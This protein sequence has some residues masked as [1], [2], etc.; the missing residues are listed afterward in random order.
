[1]TLALL[2]FL[3]SFARLSI[4]G[5]W[6]RTG[7]S[8]GTIISIAADRQNPAIWYAINGNNA[9]YGR[10]YRSTDNGESWRPTKIDK[11]TSVVVSPQS[12]EVFVLS[13][14]KDGSTRQLWVSK[15]Q[16]D[17][18]A[19]QSS[20]APLRLFLSPN[21]S[22]ILFGVPTT[23]PWNLVASF[24]GGR[25]WEEVTTLPFK[26]GLKY[27]VSPDCTFGY[28]EFKDVLISP[29]DGKTVYA[30]GEIHFQ[31]GSHN[32]DVFPVTVR[33]KNLGRSWSVS[34]FE[35]YNFSYDP[36][37]PKRAFSSNTASTSG[38]RILTE[39]GWRTL[40]RRTA[41][42]VISVPAQPEVLYAYN[43]D[44]F[45]G[46]PEY[47]VSRDF[48]RTWRKIKLGPGNGVRI[49][50]ARQTPPGSLLGGTLGGG[51]Y[52]LDE[53]GRWKAQQ[54]GFREATLVD[55]AGGPPSSI[56]YVIA[57]ESACCGSDSYLFRSTNN[58]KTWQNITDNFPAQNGAA[59]GLW[60][61]ITNP[62]N[63][64]HVIV[65]SGRVVII[66]FD[67]G[68][69]WKTLQKGSILNTYFHPVTN[70]VYFTSFRHLYRSRDGGL[71][72]EELPLKLPNSHIAFTDVEFDR[73]TNDIYLGSEQGM[74]VSDDGG[75]SMRPI[76]PEP[77]RNCFDCWVSSIVQL[78]GQG[79]FLIAATSGIYKTTDRGATWQRLSATPD[80]YPNLYPTDPDGNHVFAIHDI[81]NESND[82]GVTWK[83]I[84]RQVDPGLTGNSLTVSAMTNP[85]VLPWFISTRLGLYYKD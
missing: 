49:L 9:I 4:A 65:Q 59:H 85:F 50:V 72:I 28:Y 18:F 77:H 25:V 26:P 29:L 23:Y 22:S 24:N 12:S 44:I 67:A 38:I 41:I 32:E 27:D 13:F 71:S 2:I 17:S 20:N 73:N 11:A 7:P 42:R 45:Y 36:A 33:S 69:T 75:R 54:K 79:K 6:I 82:G 40:S 21:N 15:D 43:T 68:E 5:D 76:G 3:T 62:K 80:Y 64:K 70:E 37:F 57:R 34:E 83:N 46:A 55:V 16:G 53:Q 84:S 66:S 74:Y 30:T 8:A 47:S 61:L 19:L 78:S 35:T 51:L 31:C 14:F 60:G 10:L 58:G 63:A 81:L 52:S 1:M 56:L 48:G 39:K